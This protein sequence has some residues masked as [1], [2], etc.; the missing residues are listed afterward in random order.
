MFSIKAKQ[1]AELVGIAAK[2]S[3]GRSTQPIAE[4]IRIAFGKEEIAVYATNFETW[5]TVATPH[6]KPTV[7]DNIAIV[8]CAAFHSLITKLPGDMDVQLELKAKRLNIKAGT[9]KYTLA[10]LDDS[11]WPNIPDEKKSVEFKFEALALKETL[12]FVSRAMMTDDQTSQY[13]LCGVCMR[14]SGKKNIRFI[15]ADGHQLSQMSIAL[16]PGDLR[17]EGIIVPRQSIALYIDML[18]RIDPT[19]P[20]KMSL[21]E[22]RIKVEFSD[23]FKF[24]MTGRLIDG[25]YPNI[26]H[27]I[28]YERD[29][30]ENILP[31]APVMGAIDR[32]QIFSEEK[33]SGVCMQ[34]EKGSLNLSKSGQ[35]G[36]GVETFEV[37]KKTAPGGTITLNIKYLRNMLDGFKDENVTILCGSK[38]EFMTGTVVLKS[39]NDSVS[40]DG[41][42]SIIVPMRG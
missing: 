2:V 6:F 26:E 39:A 11:E 42:L 34:F 5:I 18:D 32:M 19:R 1:L 36:D 22:N 10:T 33:K 27:I 15:A 31:R 8:P 30:A 28:P 16:P 12:Q 38:D 23:E 24:S 21:T 9:S 37:G 20:V 3:S 14:P 4:S 41:R 29:H 35:K 7:D 40:P 25:V 13:F 17:E